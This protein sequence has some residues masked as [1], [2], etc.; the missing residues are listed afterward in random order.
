MKESIYKRIFL[1]LRICV[2][3]FFCFWLVFVFYQNWRK[4]IVLIFDYVEESDKEVEPFSG[5]LTQ[6]QELEQALGDNVGM[7]QIKASKHSYTGELTSK[8]FLLKEP[9]LPFVIDLKTQFRKANIQIEFEKKQAVDQSLFTD[10]KV[11]LL[12]FRYLPDQLSSMNFTDRPWL[13]NPG[14]I[15]KYENDYYWINDRKEKVLIK[16]IA[17]WD[18]YRF[19]FTEVDKEVFDQINVSGYQEGFS[20][21]SRGGIFVKIRDQETFYYLKSGE[22]YEVTPVVLESYGNVSI[23]EVREDEIEDFPLFIGQELGFKPGIILKQGN[24]SYWFINSKGERMRIN[25]EIV[26]DQ[27]ENFGTIINIEKTEELTYNYSGATLS[28]ENLISSGALFKGKYID[29]PAYFAY[30][31]GQI[32]QLNTFYID[33]FLTKEKNF[34][35]TDFKVIGKKEF[36]LDRN[37]GTWDFSFEPEKGLSSRENLFLAFQGFDFN[38][39][40]IKSIRAELIKNPINFQGNSLKEKASNLLRIYCEE[41]DI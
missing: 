11:Y 29:Q 30:K 9:V 21:L 10:N 34:F 32:R 37:S 19:S 6:V 7:N 8:G 17:G 12:K 22:K 39:I 35:E 16:D 28:Y 23:L 26:Q 24:S 13:V 31:G 36:E 40:Y 2:Y 25:D 41:C 5:V 20:L 27:K 38:A 15:I 3:A 33:S 1:G 4:E 18:F 14:N